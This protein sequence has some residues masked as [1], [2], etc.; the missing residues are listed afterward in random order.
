MLSELLQI[1]APSPP[2]LSEVSNM[3][4]KYWGQVTIFL[5]IWFPCD[6]ASWQLPTGVVPTHRVTMDT[7]LPWPEVLRPFANL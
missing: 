7:P 3:F 4:G 2:F 5:L 1:Q 6:S